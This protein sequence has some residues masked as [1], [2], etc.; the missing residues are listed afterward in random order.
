[1]WADLFLIGILRNI[2]FVFL[3]PS[4]YFR[5]RSNERRIRR[6]DG[7]RLRRISG[8]TPHGEGTE[9]GRNLWRRR[10]RRGEQEAWRN[11]GAERGL[12]TQRHCKP[13]RGTK[14]Y[15]ASTPS[16][17]KPEFWM[18]LFQHPGKHPSDA[19]RKNMQGLVFGDECGWVKAKVISLSGGNLL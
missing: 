15:G 19:S 2:W 14:E 1:M 7:R 12:W 13:N 3:F 16:F 17:Q 6:E 18:V 10:N 11:G 8:R 5:L 4:C 9:G